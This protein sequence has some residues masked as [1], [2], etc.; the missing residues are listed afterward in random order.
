VFKIAAISKWVIVFSGKQY[1][2][3]ICRASDDV[4]SF[5]EAVEEVKAKPN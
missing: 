4:L 5:T 2:D 3:D 1:I